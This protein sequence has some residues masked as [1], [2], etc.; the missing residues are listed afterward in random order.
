MT[1]KDIDEINIAF[2]KV[3][4]FII[5]YNL[6]YNRITD[7][8][9]YSIMMPHVSNMKHA[10]NTLVKLC[11]IISDTDCDYVYKTYVNTN[12]TI[13]YILGKR[14]T[15]GL[16]I[17][18]YGMSCEYNSKLETYENFNFLELPI[19]KNIVSISNLDQKQSDRGYSYVGEISIPQRDHDRLV[20]AFKSRSTKQA[21]QIF[22]TR[23]IKL[24]YYN[25]K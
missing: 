25:S 5:Q 22:S 7:K 14:L 4:D 10:L 15:S 1:K 20:H 18:E 24:N 9:N 2:S 23:Y 11:D 16:F 13:F 3:N 8:S 12:N 17:Y 19:I 21:M 6:I